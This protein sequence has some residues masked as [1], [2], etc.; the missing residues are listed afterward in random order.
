[1]MRTSDLTD[2]R[3]WRGWGGSTYNISFASPYT[4]PPGQES[5]HICQVTNLPG[6]PLGGMQWSAYLRTFVA[7]MDCS[8]Q[9]R[10]GLPASC[11]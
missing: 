1:M 7:T 11:A 6:C 5:Q 10:Y 4:M 2:P 3:S 8:L 9:V